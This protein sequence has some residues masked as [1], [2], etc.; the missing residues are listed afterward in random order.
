MRAGAGR[1]GTGTQTLTPTPFK[2]GGA[3]VPPSALPTHYR[4]SEGKVQPIHPDRKPR[5]PQQGDGG[6]TG[7]PLQSAAGQVY[8]HVPGT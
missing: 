1:I 4:T 6:I 8:T 3:N 7:R 2:E 5:E